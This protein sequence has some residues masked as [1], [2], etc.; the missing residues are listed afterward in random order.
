MNDRRRLYWRI[1]YLSAVFLAVLSFTPL[2]IPMGQYE[3]RL[4]GLP[5]T[6]WVGILVAIAFVVLTYAAG[7]LYPVEEAGEREA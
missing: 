1:C 3:P 2:V 5:Y 7:R 4:A 6:L